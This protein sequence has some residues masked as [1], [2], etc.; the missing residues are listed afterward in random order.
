MLRGGDNHQA[1][2]GGPQVA[3]ESGF[4]SVEKKPA[5]LPESGCKQANQGLNIG[6]QTMKTQ[7]I[8]FVGAVMAASFLL[9]CQ[10]SQDVASVPPP[11]SI[12][13]AAI[14]TVATPTT[15]PAPAPAT[16]ATSTPSTGSSPAPSPAPAVA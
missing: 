9:G 16:T 3:E 6:S 15:T 12:H 11:P 13:G 1:G 10:K 4:R 5:F 7:K 8:G 2:L 14:G